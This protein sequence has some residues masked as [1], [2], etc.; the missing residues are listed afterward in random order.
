MV[1]ILGPT[2]QLS[3][4]VMESVAVT[5]ETWPTR[6]VVIGEHHSERQLFSWLPEWPPGL[7][8]PS[9]VRRR[10][11]SRLRKRRFRGWSWPPSWPASGP[12]RWPASF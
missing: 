3:R 12:V 4:Q 8:N 5:P 9:G 10:R 6:L 2:G 11:K 1:P 7:N